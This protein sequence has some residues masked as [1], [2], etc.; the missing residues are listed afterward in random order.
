MWG[1]KSIELR[2]VLGRAQVSFNR[3]KAVDSQNKF[4]GRIANNKKKTVSLET[5]LDILRRF[6]KEEKAVGIFSVFIGMLVFVAAPKA[7]AQ[8]QNLRSYFA[9]R[10]R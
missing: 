8:P 3:R 7:S 10:I 2:Y 1:N 5:K 9:I 4:S 6:Y